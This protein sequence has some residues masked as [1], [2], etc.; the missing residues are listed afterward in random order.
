MNPC[1]RILATTIV[2]LGAV[3]AAPAAVVYTELFTAGANGWGDRDAGEMSVSHQ[4]SV[5][6]PASAA[7]QGQFSASVLPMTDAF[8]IAS[9]SDFV[10]NYTTYGNGLTSIAFDL[11]ADNVVPSD[12]FLRLVDG[13]NIYSYQLSLGSFSV[14]TWT[15]FS[16]ELDYTYG[17]LGPG[18]ATGFNTAL[19]SVDALEIQLTRNGSSSQLYYLD[20]VQTLDDPLSGGGGDGSAVPEPSSLIFVA[21]AALL[22]LN[23][24][25][26]RE[27]LSRP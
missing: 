24:R 23:R 7:M 3:H 4:A 21:L 1:R 9:G 22:V 14:D 25:A 19:T 20:N 18:G 13:S 17:W 12:L 5:G 26:V 15:T 8:R 10:G 11:Y 16:V 27:S 2:L 6:S